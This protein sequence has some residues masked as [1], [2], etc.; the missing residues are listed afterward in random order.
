MI[1]QHLSAL[2]QKNAGL[3]SEIRGTIFDINPAQS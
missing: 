2:Q 3:M 1:G